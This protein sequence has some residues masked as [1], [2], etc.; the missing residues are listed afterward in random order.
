[1]EIPH[2]DPPYE[3]NE[4]C[5]VDGEIPQFDGYDNDQVEEGPAEASVCLKHLIYKVLLSCDPCLD[6]DD[7]V[8]ATIH[9]IAP[10]VESIRSRKQ[11]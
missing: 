9:G 1:M 3:E 2:F 11:S 10:M 8:I 6:P 4:E 7:Y 5:S